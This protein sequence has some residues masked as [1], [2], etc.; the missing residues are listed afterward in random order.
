MLIIRD[1]GTEVVDIFV[2]SD[3]KRF[4]V[5]KKPLISGSDYF[6]KALNGNFKEATENA[7][8]LE[9]MVPSA[10]GL[11]IGWI[12]RGALPGMEKNISPFIRSN[13]SNPETSTVV[14]NA[15]SING[16]CYPYAT[17]LNTTSD[18]TGRE[19][20]TH[21]SAQPQYSAFSSEELRLADYS[22]TPLH[23][24]LSIRLLRSCYRQF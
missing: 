4:V 1:L 8:H 15:T 14:P 20:Y 24:F 16:T 12:Y 13:T 7:I 11:M 3:R 17:T 5:H 10:V 23:Y 6:N 19:L 22:K 21:I 18:I 9:E 2:G